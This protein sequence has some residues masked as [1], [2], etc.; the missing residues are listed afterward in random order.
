MK[1][2]KLQCDICSVSSHNLTYI[3]VATD[4]HVCSTCRTMRPVVEEL[5]I[6]SGHVARLAKGDYAE[7]ST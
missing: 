3:E 2:I 7:E 4:M 1:V 6:Q 5:L